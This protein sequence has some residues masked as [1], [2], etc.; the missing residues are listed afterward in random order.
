MIVRGKIVCF[1]AKCTHSNKPILP[2][3]WEAYQNE[4]NRFYWHLLLLV[5]TEIYQISKVHVLLSF[6]RSRILVTTK[7]HFIRPRTSE[8][9]QNS[10]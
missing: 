5:V 6:I 7:T 10:F 8:T 2:R 9:G 3:F 1:L 4:K